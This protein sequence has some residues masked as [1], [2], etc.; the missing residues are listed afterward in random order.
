MIRSLPSPDLV[1][2]LTAPPKEIHLRKQELTPDEIAAELEAWNRI[3]APKVI[4][5]DALETSRGMAYRVMSELS[6]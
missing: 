3:P 6:L 5:L 1:V 4:R 2:N